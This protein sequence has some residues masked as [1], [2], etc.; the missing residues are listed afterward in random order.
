MESTKHSLEYWTDF[1]LAPGCIGGAKPGIIPDPAPPDT[2]AL[3][4]KSIWKNQ[5]M[6]VIKTSCMFKWVRPSY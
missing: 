2:A 6:D 1:Y 4:P 5:K 3:G